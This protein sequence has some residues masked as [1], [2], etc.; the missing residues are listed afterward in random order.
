MN[1]SSIMLIDF[2]HSPCQ[3]EPRSLFSTHPSYVQKQSK[4]GAAIM[5]HKKVLSLLMMMMMMMMDD[6]ALM[7]VDFVLLLV[8]YSGLVNRNLCFTLKMGLG[9]QKGV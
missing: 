3:L 4:S 2:L 9:T 1:E 6:D 7:V 5:N 8:C